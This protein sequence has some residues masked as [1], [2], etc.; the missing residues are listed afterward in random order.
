MPPIP[1]DFGVVED[2]MAG[3]TSAAPL[4][5]PTTGTAIR[6]ARFWVLR[7]MLPYWNLSAGAS[8]LLSKPGNG[9]RP[10]ALEAALTN[11]GS[12]PTQ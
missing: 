6:R 10:A 1:E 2:A 9:R 8:A 4:R 5:K 3:T 11:L 12:K 7:M